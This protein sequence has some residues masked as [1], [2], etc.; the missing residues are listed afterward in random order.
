MNTT[1]DIRTQW[2]QAVLEGRMA[3]ALYLAPYVP[4]A[5]VTGMIRPPG[6]KHGRRTWGASG[7]IVGR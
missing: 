7:E 4:P 6:S 5:D 3:T 2:V 1:N